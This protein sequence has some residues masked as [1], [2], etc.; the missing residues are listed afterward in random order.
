MRAEPSDLLLIHAAE[1]AACASPSTAG[2][3]RAGASQAD[4]GII[5]D[6]AIA[7]RGSKII[8]VGTTDEVLRN[9]PGWLSELRPRDDAGSTRQT[10]IDATG[11]TVLPGFVDAHTHLVHAGARY[12]EHVMRLG[13]AKYLDILAAGGGILSTVRAT[14]AASPD[15]LLAAALKRL[16]TMLLHGTTTV[17]A[18][19]GYGLDATTELKQIE[20]ARALDA[21]HPVDIVSTFMGAHAV[22][23]EYSGNADGYLRFVEREMIPKIAGRGLAEFC[24]V[25]C[26]E[27]VFSVGQSRTLLRVGLEHGLKPKLHADEIHP[28]GGAELAAE[29]GAV[30]AD[31]LAAASRGGMESLAEA[32]VVAVL[33]PATM[34]TLMSDR[35]ADARAMIELGAPVALATDFNPGTSPA[36]SMQ[37]VITLAC[38]QMKMSPAEAV[39]AATANAAFAVGRGDVAGSIWPGKNGDFVVCDVPSVDALPFAV[40]VN[41]VTDVVKGGVHVVRNGIRVS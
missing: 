2:R 40:G 6:G 21:G 17:E 12:N 19:S 23:P 10:V 34:F 22:P 5:F 24:D 33:L 36:M 13:G 4:V 3:P 27:G 9:E 7:V 1:L 41:T 18:K 26:E 15:E 16:D 11:K 25:F 28:I 32:G 38:L 14:R 31:H 37:F 29:L 39:V 20:A 35:Y 8:D 30:S